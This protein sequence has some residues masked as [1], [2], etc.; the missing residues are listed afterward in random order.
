MGMSIAKMVRFCPR[1]R[2]HVRIDWR[3][4]PEKVLNDNEKFSR[5]ADANVRPRRPGRCL[6]M[7]LLLTEP[8]KVDENTA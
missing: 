2:C 8:E 4:H 7:H 1:L 6:H 5:V 3:L